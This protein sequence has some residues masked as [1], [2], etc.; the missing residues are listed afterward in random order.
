[1][2]CAFLSIGLV[3]LLPSV[4]RLGSCGADCF[5][6]NYVW[7]PRGG[8]FKTEQLAVPLVEI[9][10]LVTLCLLYSS[11]RSLTIGHPGLCFCFPCFLCDVYRQLLIP[12]VLGSP[13]PIFFFFFFKFVLTTLI[14]DQKNTINNKQC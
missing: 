1:M 11:A 14:W 9:M 6:L 10:Y 13:F 2:L 5:A 12:F 8:G 3:K 7:A 4:S